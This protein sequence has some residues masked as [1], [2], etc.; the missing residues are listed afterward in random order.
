MWSFLVET[1]IVQTSS[2]YSPGRVDHSS[3]SHSVPGPVHGQSIHPAVLVKPV[4]VSI[5]IGTPRRSATCVLRQRDVSDRYGQTMPPRRRPQRRDRV[6]RHMR[7]QACASRSAS[8]HLQ[9]LGTPFFR[10]R[11]HRA[12][13]EVG[14]VLLVHA[15]V[16]ESRSAGRVSQDPAP[17]AA[18]SRFPSTFSLAIKRSGLRRHSP[19]GRWRC[20]PWRSRSRR[21]HARSSTSTFPSYCDRYRATAQPVTPAP[22]MIQ[23]YNITPSFL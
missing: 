23:S 12:R 2:A 21:P 16:Q 19:R 5:R 9:L 3:G 20:W 8:M 17:A 4:D 13:C 7:L 1:M 14:Q 11:V 15:H 18:S 22:M 10:R 6:L